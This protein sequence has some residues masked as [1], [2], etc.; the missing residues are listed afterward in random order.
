M[1]PELLIPVCGRGARAFELPL[2]GEDVKVKCKGLTPNNIVNYSLARA[3][4]SSIT[5]GLLFSIN[6]VFKQN[7]AAQIKS[8]GKHTA[9]PSL[10]F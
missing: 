10:H 9:A 2:P 8:Y 5:P 1:S 7:I 6:F 4:Y 3:G